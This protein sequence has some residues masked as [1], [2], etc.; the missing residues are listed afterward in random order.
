M[1]PYR[2]YMHETAMDVCLFI[3]KVYR[4]SQSKYSVRAS[5]LNLGYSGRPFLIALPRRY[6]ITN[7]E[8]WVDV[9]DKINVKRVKSGLP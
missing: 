3:D 7:A 2:Y 4:V 1:R 9:T 6:T 5:T 8:Q